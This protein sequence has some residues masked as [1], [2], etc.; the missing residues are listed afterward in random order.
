MRLSRATADL[1]LLVVALVWGGTFVVVK[2]AVRV[3]PPFLLIGGRFF[4]AL[5][6]LLVCFPGRLR[7]W[8][9]SLWPG[10][11]LGTLLMAG[12][13]LQTL[14]LR[15]TAASTSGF[16]TG[17]NVVFVAL[18][19]GASLPGRI[20]P[21]TILGVTLAALG[22]F[23]LTWRPGEWRFGPGDLLTLGCAIFFALHIVVTGILAPGRDP[24]PLIGV[25]FALVALASLLLHAVTGTGLVLPGAWGWCAL[26]YLGLAATGFAFLVQTAA[27]HHTP[28][29]D[30]AVIL[31]MEP[32]FAA[33]I[34]VLLG[35]ERFTVRMALGGGA[36]FGAMLLSMLGGGRF[37]APPG[38][39]LPPPH[40]WPG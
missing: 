30:T 10:A 26:A 5:T 28:P 24:V 11:V 9:M 22:L 4:L 19:V 3:I 16:I 13:A 34:A 12:F 39:Y 36:I 33:A 17:L 32:L 7:D 21:R 40:V 8:R 31:S 25:Q 37:W 18:I 6:A 14:G 20:A 27:Q 15:Y 1:L 23:A 38:R 2:D 29:V 35:G